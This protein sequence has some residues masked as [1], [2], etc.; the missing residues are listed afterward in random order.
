MVNMTL[1]ILF[2]CFTSVL[3]LNT[4]RYVKS[5]IPQANIIMYVLGL[6]T[7]ERHIFFILISKIINQGIRLLLG[8]LLSNKS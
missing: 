5:G 2:Q 7:S 6:H 4:Y 8:T 3:Q 1:R